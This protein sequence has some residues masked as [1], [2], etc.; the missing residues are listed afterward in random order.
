MRRSGDDLGPRAMST[1]FEEFFS[2]KDKERGPGVCWL[3]SCLRAAAFHLVLMASVL[4]E[5]DNP[6]LNQLYELLVLLVA[7]SNL[8]LHGLGLYLVAF[9]PCFILHAAKR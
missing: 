8:K 1:L 2:V 4:R 9:K 5:Q 7:S 3:R 6:T